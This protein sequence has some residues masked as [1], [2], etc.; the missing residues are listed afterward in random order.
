[1]VFIV[2][3]SAARLVSAFASPRRARTALKIVKPIS[4]HCGSPFSGEDLDDD[5]GN[6]QDDLHQILILAQKHLSPRLFLPLGQ[7]IR[8]IL[9]QALL[10]LSRA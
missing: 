10:R 8:A 6:Q 2:P 9:L 1:M 5:R 3:A 7:L 4:Y